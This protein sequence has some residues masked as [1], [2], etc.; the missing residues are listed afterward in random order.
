[1]SRCFCLSTR[2][3]EI[4]SL[5][6]NYHYHGSVELNNSS[7]VGNFKLCVYSHYHCIAVALYLQT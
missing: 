5:H 4:T 7:T 3:D 1:M 6:Q 2:T